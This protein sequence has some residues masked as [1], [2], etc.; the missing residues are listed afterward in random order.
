MV[1]VAEPK[2]VRAPVDETNELGKAGVVGVE[3][4]PGGEDSCDG[5][6]ES[7][8]GPGNSEIVDDGVTGNVDTWT[9]ISEQ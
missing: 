6:R 8:D 4:V 2:V 3:G 7:A 5:S 1:G 9:R